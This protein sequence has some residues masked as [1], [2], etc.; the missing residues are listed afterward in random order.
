MGIRRADVVT[1]LVSEHLF[2]WLSAELR[3]EEGKSKHCSDK[4]CELCHWSNKCRHP[5]Q[6]GK[7]WAGQL[8]IVG[9]RIIQGRSLASV[10]PERTAVNK[11]ETSHVIYT[12]VHECA[13][14]Q[15]DVCIVFC[16]HWGEEVTQLLGDILSAHGHSLDCPSASTVEMECWV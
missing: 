11:Y 12:S 14:T 13:L 8:A 10:Y 4:G 9:R 15:C 7:H 2:K 1:C 3:R 16:I 5:I 6:L